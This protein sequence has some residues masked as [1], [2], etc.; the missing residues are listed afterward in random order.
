MTEIT[1]DIEPT[2]GKIVFVQSYRP[3]L[4]DGLYEVTVSQT[5]K[6]N[7]SSAPV[8][9]KFDE[10]FTNTRRLQVRGERFSLDRTEIE[11]QFPPPD[12]QGE[13]S[14]VLPHIVFSRRTLPWER[15]VGGVGKPTWLGLL[16]FDESEPVPVVQTAMVGDLQR[17]PFPRK[18]GGANEPSTLPQTAVSYPDLSLEPGEVLWDACNVIDVP[19]SLFN[20][21]VPGQVDMPWISHARTVTPDSPQLMELA[22]GESEI[23][24][25]V[26]VSNR[27]PD[28]NTECTVHLV[29]LENMNAFLPTGEDYTPA[30][31]TLPNGQAAQ[32]VR[33]VSLSSW[34]YRSVDPQMTFSGILLNLDKS[35][36]LRVLTVNNDA[37]KTSE[38]AKYVANALDMGFVP[39]NHHTR[40]GSNTVS[41]YRGPLTPF[42]VPPTIFVP[43]PG[44]KSHA[45]P[46]LTADEAVR[47]DPET[48]MM[49][50]SYAA[51]WQ[52]GR[53]LALQD[54]DF[55]QSL[56]RW[57]RSNTIAVVEALEREVLSEKLAAALATD[58]EVMKSA[59]PTK[60]H[61]MVVDLLR[62]PMRAMLT[63]GQATSGEE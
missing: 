16:V 35:D 6:N 25:S 15:T 2:K 39:L 19:V 37:D 47:Y 46:I 8:D 62:G 40:Q 60:M 36:G 30:K 14:N 45:P 7:D 54:K 43:D 1:A 24:S 20:Q 21:I 31:I 34:S 26:V 57:K 42:I 50:V 3:A 38:A 55:S 13:Y 10:T 56:A 18:Q 44:G 32:E 9:R 48:G 58:P 41:W 53:M 4:M 23:K 59:T 61:R 33:L 29:S 49:D 51:A 27:L 5:V 12:S 63:Q 17:N 52:I 22:D 11:S 28:P